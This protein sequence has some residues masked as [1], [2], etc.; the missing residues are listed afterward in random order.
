LSPVRPL[1]Q[2]L[3][4]ATLLTGT[5]QAAPAPRPDWLSAPRHRALDGVADDLVTAG[6]GVEGLTGPAPAAPYADP[7][8]P[9]AAELRRAVLAG[10]RDAAA[11]FG[12]LYGPNIDGDRAMPDGGRFAGDEYL[13]YADAS[14]AAS[15]NVAMLLQ[16]PRDF[17]RERPCILAIPVNGSSSLYRDITDFGFW[18]LRRGCAVAYTDKGAGNGVHDLASDTVNRLDGT[19][20]TRVEAGAD[21]HFAAP[22]ADETRQRFLAEWPHRL[23]FKH[24]HAKANPETGWGADVLRAI[25]FAFWQLNERAGEQRYTRANTLVLVAGNSNG[26]GAALYAG[27]ADGERLIDGIVVGEP[28][29]QVRPDARVAVQY[30]G[31][32]R[33][34]PGRTLLDYFTFGNLYQPCAVLALPEDAPSRAGLLARAPNR[35]ASL[36]DKGLL[37]ADALPAQ[38]EEALRRLHDYGYD[39]ALDWLHAMNYAVVPDA[40]AAKYVSAHGRF[41]VED[42]VCGLSFAAVDAE[43]RPTAIPPAVLAQSFATAPGGAPFGPVDIVNDRD[44]RGP[45]RNGLSISPSTG[46]EDFNLDGALCLRD[47][48]TGQGEAA[49][50]VQAGIRDFLASGNLHGTPTI[51]LHGRLDDRVPAGFSSRPYLGL[52]SVAEGGRSRL[53]YIEVAHAEHFG[54]SG[55]GF[56][57]RTV[58]LA[59]YLLRGL[60]SLWAHLTQGAPLPESQV[61]RTV[62]RG[63]EPGKAPPLQAG[64]IPPFPVQPDAADRIAVAEG[65][66]TIPE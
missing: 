63:G 49:R 59:A 2:G 7:A 23:A 40:T 50:R 29:V 9:T 42:R 51:I 14:E 44:P 6:L 66:V 11:G 17:A 19:T 57:T 38:A 34:D 31:Q 15:R 33:R 32:E 35:C 28:Q 61:V 30:L 41:G 48:A 47:M 8:R 37:Q 60:D 64:N 18:G 27:E 26:G 52:N 1:L 56:D 16:I 53:R 25:R 65:R 24:A 43:G 12:R 13:A 39:R 21:A 20:A 10:R 58:P 45:R 62:P 3:A 55:P 5:A 46:R 22:L 36:R 54:F 4:L